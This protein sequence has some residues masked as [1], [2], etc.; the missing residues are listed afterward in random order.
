MKRIPAIT[1]SFFM[2]IMGCRAQEDPADTVLQKL[3]HPQLAYIQYYHSSAILPFYKKWMEDSLITIAHFGD[4]HVQPD[5]Y[6]GEL[7]KRLQQQKGYAGLGMIF[8]FSAAK[9]YSTSSYSSSHTGAWLYAKSIEY[10][11]KLP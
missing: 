5:V 7:R 1:L 9:T 6:T 3:Y 8:P 4:S 2:L 11:P 10:K